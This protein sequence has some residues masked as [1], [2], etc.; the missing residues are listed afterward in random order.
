[1]RETEGLIRQGMESTPEQE[2]SRISQG[3]DDSRGLLTQQDNTNQGLAYGDEALSSAIRGK[4]SKGY[5][6]ARSGL[7][8]KMKLD[9]RNEHQ[10]KLMT[11]H[12][13]ANEEANLNFQKEM[14]KYKQKKM[15]QAQRQQLIGQVLGLTGAVVGGV[16][17]GPAGAAAGGAA[18]NMVGGGMSQGQG[19]GQNGLS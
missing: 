17:G 9:A 16:Y 8:N 14:I 19:G 3:V 10:A 11:A 7:E 13:M 4:M 18:G 15:K 2:Y 1:M 12:Q 6:V 5:N